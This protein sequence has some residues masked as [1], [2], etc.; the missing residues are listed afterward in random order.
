MDLKQHIKEAVINYFN[1][2]PHGKSSAGLTNSDSDYITIKRERFVY[3]VYLT[4]NF[5][6]MDVEGE[7]VNKETELLTKHRNL[8]QAK[9]IALTYAKEHGNLPVYI[10]NRKG[11][12]SELTEIGGGHLNANTF[13]IP[14]NPLDRDD[15]TPNSHIVN[16]LPR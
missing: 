10:I 11:E 8:K 9:K 12:K 3:N 13:D 14:K 15:I 5:V 6:S 7:Y 16:N 2:M 1:E 4:F